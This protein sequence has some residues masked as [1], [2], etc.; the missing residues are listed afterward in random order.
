MTL[1]TPNEAVGE[2]FK[3]IA[4][5]ELVWLT[6]VGVIIYNNREKLVSVIKRIM[7]K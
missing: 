6:I 1:L 4:I 3:H 2:Q 5:M 7:K